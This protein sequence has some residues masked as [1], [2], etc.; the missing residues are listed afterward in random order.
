MVTF[1]KKK[2]KKK[3]EGKDLMQKILAI[4]FKQYKI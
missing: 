4:D 1:K 3:I 2:T